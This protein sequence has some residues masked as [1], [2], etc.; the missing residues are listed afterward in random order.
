MIDSIFGFITDGESLVISDWSN[1]TVELIRNFVNFSLVMSMVEHD[2]CNYKVPGSSET[3]HW[4][5]YSTRVLMLF[6]GG[7]LERD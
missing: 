5:T 2:S 1:Q 3:V 7:R 4:L 6:P